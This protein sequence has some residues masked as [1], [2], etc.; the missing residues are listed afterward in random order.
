MQTQTPVVILCQ[1]VLTGELAGARHYPS[2]RLTWGLP[3]P[4]LGSRKG[5]AFCGEGS[6][7]GGWSI[8]G[9]ADYSR[10]AWGWL[11]GATRTKGYLI[12]KIPQPACQF[13][14]LR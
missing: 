1:A 13:S 2:L 12:P 8:Q 9:L 14:L 3:A 4:S 7:S 10:Q 5:G 6:P 11:C